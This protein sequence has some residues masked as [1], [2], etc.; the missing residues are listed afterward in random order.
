MSSAALE[1]ID[2]LP[3][4]EVSHAYGNAGDAPSELRR[5]LSDDEDERMDAICGF[6]LSSAFHQYSIYPATPYAM[7]SVIKILE[8]GEINA[9]ESGMGDSMV[10]QLLHFVRIFAERGQAAIEGRPDP[11]AP[12]VEKAAASGR[13]IYQQMTADACPKV[14]AEAT[15][16]LALIAKKQRARHQE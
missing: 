6:L 11:F 5:L 3:W 2:S 1:F 12:T 7:V 14:R 9:L 4:K 13:Q 16:L 10:S 8:S 15:A